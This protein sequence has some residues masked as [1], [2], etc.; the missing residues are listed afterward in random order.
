MFRLC[1]FASCFLSFPLQAFSLA[2]R[3]G[4]S[5]Q[6]SLVSQAQKDR[7][8]ACG[9]GRLSPLLGGE[10]SCT[11][12]PRLVAHWC[13]GPIVTSLAEVWGVPKV[14]GSS[15]GPSR[16][17]NVCHVGKAAVKKLASLNALSLPPFIP[18]RT[19]WWWC[20]PETFSHV[21]FSNWG[22]GLSSLTVPQDHF[23]SSPVC[24]LFTL[25]VSGVLLVILDISA[26]CCCCF[27]LCSV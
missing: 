17:G 12:F 20:L 8:G 5:R 19:G 10:G 4:S 3:V 13:F 24:R 27:S 2:E 22:S 14:L 9:Q 18:V 25:L 26:L 7:G 16:L 1:Y 11:A 23:P 15:V 6:L 21:T